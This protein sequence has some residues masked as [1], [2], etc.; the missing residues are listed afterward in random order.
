MQGSSA[1][2]ALIGTGAVSM[3]AYTDATGS[4]MITFWEHAISKSINRTANVK[5]AFMI[6]LSL[7]LVVLKKPL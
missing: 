4:V 5:S 1:A 3:V 6:C 7:N 2:S